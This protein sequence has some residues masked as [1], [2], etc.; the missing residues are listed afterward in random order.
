[1]EESVAK[2]LYLREKPALSGSMGIICRYLE[3]V[4]Q[5]LRVTIKSCIYKLNFLYSN[6]GI[7]TVSPHD[8]LVN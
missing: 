4:H 6:Y 1:M 2:R 8:F 7:M 5:T 3:I